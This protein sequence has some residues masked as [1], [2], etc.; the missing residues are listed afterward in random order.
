[1]NNKPKA[2]HRNQEKSKQLFVDM[3]RKSIYLA[4]QKKSEYRRNFLPFDYYDFCITAKENENLRCRNKLRDYLHTP[5]DW[6]EDLDIYI[7]PVSDNNLN[8][9]S[10]TQPSQGN[11]K[12]SKKVIV[13]RPSQERQVIASFFKSITKFISKDFNF[14]Q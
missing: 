3:S 10:Q 9:S 11:G 13:P 1:M 2:R 8:Q 4:S 14:A 12:Q 6:D 5:F 7:E